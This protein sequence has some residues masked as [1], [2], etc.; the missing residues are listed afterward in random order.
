MLGREFHLTPG[1]NMREVK[2]CFYYIPLLSSLQAM[3][4]C[5]DISDQV[6]YIYAQIEACIPTLVMILLL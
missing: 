6:G 4:K 2:D 1:G 3:L 5:K